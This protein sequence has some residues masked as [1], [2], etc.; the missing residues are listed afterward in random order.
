LQST[1]LAAVDWLRLTSLRPP[2]SA[3]Y[4]SLA[5]MHDDLDHY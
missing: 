1:L 3:I 2:S 5:V 4:S